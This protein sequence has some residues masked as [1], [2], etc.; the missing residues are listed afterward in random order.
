[1]VHVILK[2]LYPAL[3]C[4]LLLLPAFVFAID[5]GVQ[6][7]PAMGWN[8][9]NQL[10]CGGL[11]QAAVL[12]QAIAMA[13]K[14]PAQ[15]DW[16]GRKLSM[17][18]AG[19]RFINLDDCWEGS[20]N[21][22]Y[23]TNLF[24][25]GFNWMCDSIRRLGLFPGIYTSAGSTTCAG[26]PA[27]LNADAA[28]AKAYAD[29][30]FQ[31]L[32]EDWCATPSTSQSAAGATA[33]YQASYKALRTAAENAATSGR[34][35][36]K[37]YADSTS[38]RY[39]TFSLCNWGNWNVW[40][41]G[42]SC[43]HSARSSGDIA[44]NWTNMLNILDNAAS[45]NITSYNAT[46]FYCDQDMMEIGVSTGAGSLTAVENQTHY[47]LWAQMQSPL[48]A[49]NNLST[50][51]DAVLTIYL[52]TEVNDINQD[53]LAWSGRR[54][55]QASGIDLWYK[56]CFTRNPTTHAVITDQTQMKKSVIVFN[57]NS[58]QST[59]S[60]LRTDPLE[61]G[62]GTAY[63]VRDLWKHA[64]I[65]TLTTTGTSIP[66]VSVVAHGTVHLLFT[67]LGIT[68]I[69]IPDNQLKQHSDNMITSLIKERKGANGFEVFI[70]AR[71]KI[72]LFDVQGKQIAS[73]L[74]ENGGQWYRMPISGACSAVFVRA[75]L[76][77]RVVSK[78]LVLGR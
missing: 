16:L 74:A 71:G 50:M 67:P 15:A 53:S 73:F 72:T 51:S 26:R 23:N 56:R 69:V 75:A 78:K 20:S 44:S 28:C 48:L 60:I 10:G 41:Y 33:L 45:R 64:N 37:G 61:F 58:S 57:R 40:T 14:R 54:V 52:N 19:Y 8:S 62:A 76:Q 65:C 27:Q 13:T 59:Y 49:G 63:Q 29:W 7:T 22:S 46:G 2:K 39:F 34:W 42:A 55:K 25:Q 77:D 24:P 9:W 31:Y 70:P 36:G 3:G 35:K 21:T 38:P 4:A 66:A 47:D 17:K 1:M 18:E 5:D 30:G 12:A 43:G 6:K 32:K 68:S 11:N